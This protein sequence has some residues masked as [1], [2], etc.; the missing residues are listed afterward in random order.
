MLHLII[1]IFLIVIFRE[2][3]SKNWN[4]DGKLE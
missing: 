3:R 4:R 1:S 2:S